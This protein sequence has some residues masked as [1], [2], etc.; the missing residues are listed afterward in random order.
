VEILKAGFMDGKEYTLQEFCL[1]LK[2]GIWRTG[3]VAGWGRTETVTVSA[4]GMTDRGFCLRRTPETY[5]R[6]PLIKKQL[7]HGL[8]LLD[9]YCLTKRNAAKESVR[10]AVIAVCRATA[11]SIESLYC[12]R[13]TGR[14]DD[15]V[16]KSGSSARNYFQE[17][18]NRRDGRRYR[19][20]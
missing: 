15:A 20:R 14:S 7:S 6:S 9:S 18:K 1:R 17:A 10:V 11:D 2:L 12:L 3:A 8:F 16:E 19:T 13:I 4:D 5:R